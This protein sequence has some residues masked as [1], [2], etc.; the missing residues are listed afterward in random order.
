MSLVMCIYFI[1]NHF[2]YLSISLSNIDFVFFVCF[3]SLYPTNKPA[4]ILIGFVKLN[5]TVVTSDQPGASDLN[6]L[7]RSG[8]RVASSRRREPIGARPLYDVTLPPPSVADHMLWVP[9]VTSLTS[10]RG[11][12]V[13]WQS[14]PWNSYRFFLL[15]FITFWRHKCL[16]PQMR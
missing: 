14:Y 2:I 10:L 12:W 15:F 7:W 6:R 13:C 4:V 5:L 1:R 8:Q 9:R 16:F 11:A 3:S